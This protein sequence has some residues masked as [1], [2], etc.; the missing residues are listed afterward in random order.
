MALSA[1]VLISGCGDRTKRAYA[2]AAQAQ[3]LLDAGDLQGAQIAIARAISLRGDQIE[4]QLLNGRINYQRK[5]YQGAFEAYSLALSIDPMNPEALQAV[6]Q[7]GASMGREAESTAATNR[8]LSNDPN[9][10]PALLVKGVQLLGRKDIDGAQAVGEQMLKVDPKNEAGMVL[11]ARAMFL[12]NQ[13]PEAL[14]L[15]RD[16][17]KQIG[18]TQMI[19]S[20]LLECARDQGDS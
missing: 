5:D 12:N 2:E 11:K 19:V 9:N 20:A 14:A 16:G 3:A 15:L 8:I 7:I 6:S 13:Q 1:T 18:P 10:L 17:L 4:F